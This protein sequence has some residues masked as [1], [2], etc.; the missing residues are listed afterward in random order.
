MEQEGE[1]KAIL[2]KLDEE[3]WTQLKAIMRFEKIKNMSDVLRNMISDKYRGLP[4]KDTIK[5]GVATPQS[6]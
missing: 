4:K 3:Q 6:S 1:G 2:L 5:L